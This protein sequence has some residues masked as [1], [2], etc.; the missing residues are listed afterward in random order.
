M[1]YIA[2]RIHKPAIDEIASGR[3]EPVHYMAKYRPRPGISPD[4]A[5]VVSA[6]D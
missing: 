3:R 5:S 1:F 4:G 6:P 2:A